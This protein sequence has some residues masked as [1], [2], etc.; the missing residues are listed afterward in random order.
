MWERFLSFETDSG[1]RGWSLDFLLSRKLS[2]VDNVLEQQL[3]I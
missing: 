3:V 2:V 1:S